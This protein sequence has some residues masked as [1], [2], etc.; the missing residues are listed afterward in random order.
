M[1]RDKEPWAITLALAVTSSLQ[2]LNTNPRAFS[3]VLMAGMFQL[4]VQPCHGKGMEGQWWQ[5]DCSTS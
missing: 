3:D 2:C 5:Q 4:S 1:E